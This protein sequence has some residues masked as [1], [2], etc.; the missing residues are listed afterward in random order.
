MRVERF[1]YVGLVMEGRG[2][3]KEDVVDRVVVKEKNWRKCHENCVLK[4]SQLS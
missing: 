2:S 4:R 1:K 3:I